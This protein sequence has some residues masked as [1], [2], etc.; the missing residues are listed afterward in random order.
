MTD[1]PLVRAQQLEMEFSS[2]SIALRDVSFS[3][4]DSEFVSLI[5]PS[6]CG[7][8]TLL[9]L[10]AGL[11]EPTGGTLSVGGVSAL[12]ARQRAHRTAFVFQ[13]PTLLPWRSVAGNVCLPL[14][15]ERS[16]AAERHEAVA[17]SLRLVGLN[18]RDAAKRP[19]MLS[20]GMQMRVSLARAL[21]T[22]PDLLLLDEPFA[23]LD[24]I[25][26]QQLNDE[27]LRIW[28][29]Q[30]CT[31]VFVTHNVAEAVYLSGRILVMGRTPGTI[32]SEIDVPFEFPRTA[33]LRASAAFARLT[34]EVGR[35]LQEAIQ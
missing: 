35:T 32:V 20:G 26:R 11:G 2:E 12:E 15:L 4:E 1:P 22:Q 5:G 8:S 31:A 18:D 28:K 14:E 21:V 16:S 7:K 27:L 6:G 9:R 23:A 30:R 3:V 29:Q 34:G 19:H 13:A 24:D 25:L 33:E 17:G 10:M